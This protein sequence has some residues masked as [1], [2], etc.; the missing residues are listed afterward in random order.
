MLRNKIIPSSRIKC[1][2]RDKKILFH[3]FSAPDPKFLPFGGSEISKLRYKTFRHR[4]VRRLHLCR[5]EPDGEQGF[6]YR[7][8]ESS[9]EDLSAKP[10][11]G[12]WGFILGL[13]GVWKLSGGRGPGPCSRGL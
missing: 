9:W 5:E 7:K 6:G 12:S 2:E 4:I 3:L 1:G 11:R 10:G 8:L 13:R